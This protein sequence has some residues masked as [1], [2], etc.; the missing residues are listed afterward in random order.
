MPTYH[1]R[2]WI[3]ILAAFAPVVAVFVAVGVGL[4]QLYLQRQQW[5]QNL[6]DKR[7]VVYDAVKEYM[8]AVWCAYGKQGIDDYWRFR[9]ATDSTK[10]LFGPIVTAFVDHVHEIGENTVNKMCA[11][12]RW[13]N[14]YDGQ[15]TPDNLSQL[16]TAKAALDSEIS[17]LRDMLSN[18]DPLFGPYLQL[19]RELPWYARLQEYLDE[20]VQKLDKTLNRSSGKV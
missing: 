9:Q 1:T 13:Q 14:A 15:P 2:D 3:D 19:H 20:S 12:E 6:Y 8:S 16:T 18:L 10:F 17:Q 11:V 4:M 5:K 7:Y